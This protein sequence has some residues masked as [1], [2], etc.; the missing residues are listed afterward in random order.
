MT[1]LFS[2]TEDAEEV[3]EEEMRMG[4]AEEELTRPLVPVRIS[5]GMG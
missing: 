3:M 5:R 2:K 4:E 1:S